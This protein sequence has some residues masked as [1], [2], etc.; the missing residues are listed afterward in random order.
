M[1][2]T[3]HSEQ[4]AGTTWRTRRVTV[5]RT[6]V[7]RRAPPGRNETASEQVPVRSRCTAA[8]RNVDTLVWRCCCCCWGCAADARAR[9]KAGAAPLFHWRWLTLQR[10]QRSSL[11]RRFVNSIDLTPAACGHDNNGLSRN[12]RLTCGAISIYRTLIKS[13]I[14]RQSH[15]N[16]FICGQ[17]VSP[18]HD[19]IQVHWVKGNGRYLTRGSDTK[20]LIFL[21]SKNG[22]HRKFELGACNWQ[23]ILCQKVKTATV[24]RYV[25]SAISPAL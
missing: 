15:S 5:Q 6:L 24:L 19:H 2:V 18:V 14:Y 25:V 3:Y 9:L 13:L 16:R 1:Y 23:C 17:H 11:R 21:S 10:R 8:G 22:N 12:T 20:W 7:G 4:R